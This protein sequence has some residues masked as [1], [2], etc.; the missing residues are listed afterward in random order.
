MRKCKAKVRETAVCKG[1][2]TELDY[3]STSPE[4]CIIIEAP[5]SNCIYEMVY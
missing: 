4:V 2:R 1:R 5:E 3:R